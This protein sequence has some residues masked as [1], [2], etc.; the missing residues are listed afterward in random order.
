MEDKELISKIS[1]GDE[2][3]FNMLYERYKVRVYNTV[4]SYLRDIEASE[5]I[6]QDIFI[7][8]YNSAG[9]FQ[10]SSTVNTWIYRIA[11]NKCL[12]R[13]RYQKRKKRFG[14]LQSIFNKDTGSLQHDKPDFEHPGIMLENKEKALILFKAIE[15][16][17]EQQQTAYILSF[18]EELPGKEVA[19]I[20]GMGVKAI[21][22]LKQRAKARLRNELSKFYPERRKT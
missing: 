9:K 5:E 16:L 6:T 14:F 20:M 18:I 17:N 3:A 4:L 8:I 7:E 21:E 15:N 11:V 12:D 2:R 13:L 22:S 19:E 10:G 1:E